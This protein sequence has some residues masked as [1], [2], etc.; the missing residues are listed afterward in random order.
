VG[1]IFKLVGSAQDWRH[2]TRHLH[3]RQR[4]GAWLLHTVFFFGSLP[5]RCLVGAVKGG[6]ILA[7]DFFQCW[8]YRILKLP[9]SAKYK[10]LLDYIDEFESSIRSAGTHYPLALPNIENRVDVRRKFFRKPVVLVVDDEVDQANMLAEELQETG[11]YQVE[12][13]YDGQDALEKVR[14][15]RQ[16]LGFLRSRIA[17]ILLDYRMPRMNGEQFLKILRVQ[18]RKN[19]FFNFTPVVMLTAYQD[20]ENWGFASDEI[21]GMCCG[22][23]IKPYDRH[24]LKTRVEDVTFYDKADLLIHKTR[25]DRNKVVKKERDSHMKQVEEKKRKDYQTM[26]AAEIK[27][28]EET[29]QLL[30]ESKSLLDRIN[31]VNSRLTTLTQPKK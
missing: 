28:T 4:L 18:E 17:C 29:H 7:W 30:K 21:L 15:Y 23:I 25:E 27:K 31:R 14:Q 16:G 13:A 19:T 8:E 6:H 24:Y 12:T 9:N 11:L 2:I 22:Y 5:I 1:P 26:V 10:A 20:T 3:P